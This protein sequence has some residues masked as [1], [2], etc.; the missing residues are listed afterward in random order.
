[1]LE[2]GL[3]PIPGHRLTRRLGAGGFGEVW[4][5]LDKD[6]RPVALKF[7]DCRAR[8][9]SLISSEIRVLRALR[10]LRHPNIIELYGVCAS[11]HYIILSMERADG[12]LGDLR[13]A[14]REEAGTDIPAEHT[15]ELLE[16]ASVAL[17]FLAGVKLPGI[18]ASSGGL[19]HCD[20]KPANLLL[21]G[22]CVK[23]AD[24]GLCV[25]T[26]W[27]GQRGYW[28]GTPP[29][30]AP[31]LYRGAATV[32]TDQYALAVTFC[33]LCMGDRPFWKRD[34]KA[35]APA[36]LPID[37]T[38]LREHELPVLTRALHPH[39]SSRWPSCQAFLAALRAAQTAR[40]PTRGRSGLRRRPTGVSPPAR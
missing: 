17:D 26:S 38:K 16:Q 37:L 34:W 29:Y 4:E 15:L 22:E 7:L 25:G 24:F 40:K 28:R 8:S 13:Q 1:M 39:P 27:Q 32:G 21:L 31:E 35:G 20:V 23:V 18:N 10:E 14:Y 19:Q 36:G 12:N 9:P 33:E 11:S 2:A 3:Q 6:G 5:A 30:A